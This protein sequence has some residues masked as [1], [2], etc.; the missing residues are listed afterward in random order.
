MSLLETSSLITS[1]NHKPAHV[2]SHLMNRATSE[3]HVSNVAS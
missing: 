1:S 3:V 2:V